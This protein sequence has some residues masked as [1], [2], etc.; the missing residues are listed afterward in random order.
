MD[1]LIPRIFKSRP[2]L[3]EIESDLRI[4]TCSVCDLCNLFFKKIVNFSIHS[5][6]KTLSAVIRINKSRDF[7]IIIESPVNIFAEKVIA[8]GNI[9]FITADPD[10]F[11]LCIIGTV[12]IFIGGLF[13]VVR[14][15]FIGRFITIARIVFALI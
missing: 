11:Y 12:L 6:C 1:Y 7:S 10:L 3:I 8:V 14:A 9:Q 2:R 15:V 13:T 5:I 4:G